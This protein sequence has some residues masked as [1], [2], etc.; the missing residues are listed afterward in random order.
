MTTNRLICIGHRGASGYLPEN[1]LPSFEKAIQLGCDWVELDVYLVENELLVIHDERVDR[2]TNGTGVVSELDL[3]YIRSL[4]AGGGAGVPTLPEVI[5]AIDHRCGI[6]IE[7]KGNATAVAATRILNDYC[8]RGW[9]RTE[10]LISSFKHQELAKMDAGY[11]RGAL[12]VNITDDIWE[13]SARLDAWSVHL[14]CGS[15]NQAIVDEAHSRGYRVLVYTVDNPGDIA[16]LAGFGVDGLF[17]NFPD[18]VLLH[19]GMKSQSD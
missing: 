12:F 16:R 4:D 13:R 11:R 15:I 9:D 6:N 19:A 7:L 14:A 3:A 17:S 5:D 2:T 1:T 18:R 8:S 10:F